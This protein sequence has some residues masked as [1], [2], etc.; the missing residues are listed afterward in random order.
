MKDGR[1]IESGKHLELL[2]KKGAYYQLVQKQ[3]L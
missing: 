2:A 3:T 1:V